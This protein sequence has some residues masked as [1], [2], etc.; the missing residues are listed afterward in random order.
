[1]SCLFKEFLDELNTMFMPLELENNSGGELAFKQ[2]SKC[3][4]WPVYQNAEEMLPPWRYSKDIWTWSWVTISRWP[5]LSRGL[6]KMISRGPFQLQHYCGSLK[7]YFGVK[8]LTWPFKWEFCQ[9]HPGPSFFFL[10]PCSQDD[11]M[12]CNTNCSG[13]CCSTLRHCPHPLA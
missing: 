12:T 2:T 4:N 13:W 11:S 1:M 7:T 10:L 8:S 5:C 6:N 9:L 3:K